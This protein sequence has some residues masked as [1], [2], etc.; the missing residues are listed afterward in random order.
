MDKK[1][2]AKLPWD[3]DPNLDVSVEDQLEFKKKAKNVVKLKKT[4]NIIFLTLGA[5]GI[6]TVLGV[7]LGVK[8]TKSSLNIWKESVTTK[9]ANNFDANI[10][11]WNKNA[12]YDGSSFDLAKKLMTN[13][14]L[15]NSALS[16]YNFSLNQD[17][18]AEIHN[19]ILDVLNPDTVYIDVL[20][21]NRLTA[22]SIVARN[23]TL[24]ATQSHTLLDEKGIEK[25]NKDKKIDDLANSQ[26]EL[27]FVTDGRFNDSDPENNTFKQ[28]KNKIELVNQKIKANNENYIDLGLYLIEHGPAS[29]Y[30]LKFT[31]KSQIAAYFLPF[32][33]KSPISLVKK[34]EDYYL[35]FDAQFYSMAKDTTKIKNRN[36]EY[37]FYVPALE[38][39]YSI[40]LTFTNEK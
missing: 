21:T 18:N 37:G 1:T 16:V 31:K 26:W 33:F 8:T 30:Y 25:F 2:N 10:L 28:L 13:L 15:K 19:V 35:E 9:I 11:N 39:K 34:G 27:A 24:K 3:E 12:K 29:N 5:V 40:K 4:R 36:Y 14:S 23:L 17:Y 38:K 20:L 6:A 7:A 32:N 22:A